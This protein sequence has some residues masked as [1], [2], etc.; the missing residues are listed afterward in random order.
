[1]HKTV[2]VFDDSQNKNIH[3][4]DMHTEEDILIT[5][6]NHNGNL[7]YHLE[8]TIGRLSKQTANPAEQYRNTANVNFAFGELQLQNNKQ[9]QPDT[10]LRIRGALKNEVSADGII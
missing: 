10:H 5:P 7:P 3:K 4:F 1:M 8:G 2:E 9:S 6:D